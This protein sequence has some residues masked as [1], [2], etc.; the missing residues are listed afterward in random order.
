LTLNTVA[1]ANLQAAAKQEGV[2][3]RVITAI[4]N[5]EPRR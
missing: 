3:S 1:A 4:S 5:N 2:S